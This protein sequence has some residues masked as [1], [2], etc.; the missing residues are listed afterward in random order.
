M[1]KALYRAH[2]PQTFDE[3]V[4]QEAI[5]TALKNQVKSGRIGHA[6]L[7]AGTRGT[8]KTSCA[9]IFA[10]AVNCLHPQDGSPCNE[11]ENCRA[12]LD[13]T[14]MDVVEMDAAS[15]R[16]IDD[17]RE[18]R[19]TVKYPPTT[20]R[21]KV[22]IIDEA[23]MITNEAFN[24]LLKIMEEPPEHLIFILATTEPEKIPQTILSRVQRYEFKRI[25]VTL[26]AERLQ[27]VAA[28]AGVHLDA[29]AREAIALAAD[30]AM[31]D[32]LSLL[33][34]VIAM[35]ETDITAQTVER[36]LGTA[37]FQAFAPLVDAIV[38]ERMS[39]AY[40]V[41]WSLLRAGREPQVL[42]RELTDFYRRLLLVK[43]AGD[44]LRLPLS[45]PE[46]ARLDA[47]AADV[48]MRRLLDGVDLLIDADARIRKSE[49]AEALFLAVVG[50]L[51]DSPSPHVLESRVAALEEKLAAI[52]RWQTPQRDWQDDI[53]REVAAQWERFGATLNAGVM[54]HGEAPATEADDIKRPQEPEKP[55]QEAPGSVAESAFRRDPERFLREH[56][57]EWQKRVMAAKIVVPALLGHYQSIEVHDRHVTFHYPPG[58]ITAGVL[59]NKE[60]AL[61]R[62]LSA[63]V[64]EPLEVHIGK[65]S[66][67]QQTMFHA[68]QSERESLFHSPAK[69]EAAQTGDLAPASPERTSGA[70]ATPSAAASTSGETG[71]QVSAHVDVPDQTARDASEPGLWEK[72]QAVIPPELLKKED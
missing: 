26:I 61:S 37:G 53:A 30:G 10:R 65:P 70:K 55:A 51:I 59:R 31:R 67:Q 12:V 68:K 19:D 20:L 18:L 22:Y 42:L 9:K 33:D 69:A 64:G 28:D 3:V 4:G 24:A 72:L 5:V 11:C 6:Y 46:R 14:T 49:A 47:W 56:R 25:P 1:Q 36:V 13:E 17:I 58:D 44:A 27:K 29:D 52:G 43:G 38:H 39:E 23:H 57:A 66:A 41:A 50:R 2:R 48:P 21:Y 7:F 8:G 35:G 15:N 71:T 45:E 54:A 34:Q 63:L 60:E 32:A 16:R 62:E 40:Q